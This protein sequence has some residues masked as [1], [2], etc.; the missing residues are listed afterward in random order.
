MSNYI[1]VRSMEEVAYLLNVLFTNMNNL[2]RVYYDM[3]INP[4]QMDIELERYDE[5]GVLTKVVL[6][7]RAKDKI[8]TYVGTGN[9]NGN[10]IASV[11]ALYIDTTSTSLYYKGSGSDA[12]GWFVLWSSSNLIS[13]TDYLPPNGNGSQ[14]ANLNANNITG[15]ILSVTRGGTGTT[16]LN[17]IIK[18]NGVNAFTSATDGSDYLG[19][20]SF[21]GLIAFYPIN[22]IPT[23]WLYCD[24]AAY[25]RALYS[26]LFNKIG[27][28]YG[29]GDGTTTFNVPDLR[30]YFIKCWDGAREFNSV[31]DGKV[32]SH[33]HELAGSTGVGS[34]HSHS[35][36]SMRITGTITTSLA[37]PSLQEG[38]TTGALELT[39]A[40]AKTVST[41][42]S[43]ANQTTL[44][45][46][47]DN[48]E[49]SGWTGI[50]SSENSH[51][52]SLSGCYTAENAVGQENT[53]KNKALVPIIKY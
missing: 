42:T 30:D 5:N 43:G 45:L 44:V 41:T 38:G 31:E 14:L 36:G 1:E 37:W 9:P 2:D 29:A 11:G 23:G 25:S 6:P 52:H 40:A 33:T 7:N 28:S 35:R 13:G 47:T 3:F 27:I 15:G 4:Q 51:I 32:G 53:V 22:S 49:G 24:G 50:T 18:G 16:S 20:S 10:Q 17:G 26:R 8:T 34:P 48:N 39:G 12:Y 46:D 19:P 21:T